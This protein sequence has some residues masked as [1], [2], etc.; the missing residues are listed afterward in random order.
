MG[1]LRVLAGFQS[2]TAGHLN[3]R[4][5]PVQEQVVKPLPFNLF[6]ELSSLLF[7]KPQGLTGREIYPCTAAIPGSTLPSRYSSMAPPPVLT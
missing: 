5:N 2:A 1:S 3:A 4:L 6:A 7:A